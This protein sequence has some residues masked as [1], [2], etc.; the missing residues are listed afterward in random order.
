MS[1]RNGRWFRLYDNTLDD[2]KVQRLSLENFQAWINLLCLTSKHDGT[3]PPI[4]EIAFRL[5]KS[6]HRMAKI[7]GELQIV[8][9]LD[10]TEDGLLRPHN[11]EELQYKS[12]TSAERMRKLRKGKSDGDCDVTSDGDCDVTS[13]AHVR[14]L[15]VSVSDSESEYDS[16]SRKQVRGYSMNLIGRHALTPPEY[17][18]GCKV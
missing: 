13:D 14:H 16:V 17:I 2:P 15:S 3:L 9:L 1:K 11:W 12:D 5:R 18:I 8:E 10:Q 4:E 6:P 7:V